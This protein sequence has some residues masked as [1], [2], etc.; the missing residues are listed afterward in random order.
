[1]DENTTVLKVFDSVIAGGSKG[2]ERPPL[3]GSDQMG[4]D[5]AALDISYWRQIARRINNWRADSLLESKGTKGKGLKLHQLA[6]SSVV[7]L[8]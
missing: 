4:K 7:S 1:M 2:R 3:C 5:L 8:L 6:A